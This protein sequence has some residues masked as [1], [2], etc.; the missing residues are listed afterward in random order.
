MAGKSSL[1][2]TFLAY[3]AKVW[4]IK[5]PVDCA[6]HQSPKN[7]STEIIDLI[8]KKNLKRNIYTYVDN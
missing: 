5:D 1:G 6:S 3:L 7:K 8:M 4:D 2:F